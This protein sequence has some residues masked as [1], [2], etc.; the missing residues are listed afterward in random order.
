M[1]S[2]KWYEKG[3]VALAAWLKENFGQDC[4]DVQVYM[5]FE[6]GARIVEIAFLTGSGGA[7][8]Q[9]DEASAFGCGF[10]I[11]ACEDFILRREIKPHRPE[12]W[13]SDIDLFQDAKDRITQAMQ[14]C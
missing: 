1:K 14:P 5:D 3:M 2:Q 10:L 12:G 6:H 4:D 8:Y 11:L 9:R 13:E 7:S